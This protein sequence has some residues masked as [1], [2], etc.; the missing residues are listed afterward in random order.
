MRG[1]HIINDA[2]MGVSVL[3]ISD[4]TALD[5]RLEY[6]RSKAQAIQ[7]WTF[8]DAGVALYKFA[9]VHS[10]NGIVVELGSWKGQ[11]T[12]WLGYG[13]ED[14]SDGGRVYAVD[15]WQ[16]SFEEEKHKKYLEG[17]S[18]N[19]LYEE[20]IQNMK[21]NGLDQITV[22]IRGDTLEVARQW[23]LDTRIGLLHIDASHEYEEVR[24]D[25]E[26]WSPHVLTGGFIV[27]DDVPYWP[28]PTRLITELPKWYRQIGVT[29][30]KM[31]FV[32]NY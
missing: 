25:F 13:I 1:S 5:K 23:P 24:R 26:F 16:G 17:Y 21:N 30:N 29:N 19:Q 28:G 22:P 14:R 8:D 32:K 7:G 20:F 6:I 10:P 31:I 15:T 3:D 9:S 27:F 12:L 11:S 4:Q 18:E 2:T